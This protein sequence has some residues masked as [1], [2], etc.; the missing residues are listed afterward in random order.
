ML[1]QIGTREFLDL[2]FKFP[3]ESPSDCVPFETESTFT[4]LRRHILESRRSSATLRCPGRKRTC[5]LRLPPPLFPRRMSRPQAFRSSTFT[6][7]TYFIKYPAQTIESGNH[8]SISSLTSRRPCALWN[9]VGRGAAQH[10]QSRGAE[11]LRRASCRA[12]PILATY[13]FVRLGAR[14]VRAVTI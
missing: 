14:I 6:P 5:P 11:D 13:S 4:V 1:R 12:Y 3:G 7:A 2:F 8:P 10:E 9:I